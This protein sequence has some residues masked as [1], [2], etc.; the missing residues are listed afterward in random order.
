VKQDGKTPSFSAN[1]TLG[2]ETLE[3]VDC[4]NGKTIPIEV[5]IKGQG[6]NTHT[7]QGVSRLCKRNLFYSW[8]ELK[9]KFSMLYP[10]GAEESGKHLSDD[11]YYCD[12]KAMNKD[13]QAAKR[14]LFK[15]L[16][17][18]QLGNWVEK[19]IDQDM[20]SL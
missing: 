14:C 16:A 7:P 3:I 5:I 1:W 11:A 18:H 17:D 10:S 6:V 9:S 8:M 2:D 12:L 19:P 4:G 20:F 13:F 15:V